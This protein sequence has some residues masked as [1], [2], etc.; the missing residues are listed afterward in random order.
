MS[1]KHLMT[2]EDLWRMPEIPGKNVEL[3]DGEVVAVSPAGMGHGL[4]TGNLYEAMK[5]HVRRNALGIVVG[6]NV[7]YVLRRD[8]DEVRAPDVSFIALER[9]PKTG[10]LETRFWEGPPTLAVEVVSPDD[11]MSDV[12]AK[13]QH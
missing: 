13:V 5:G 3:I 11:R 1:V 8:P 7:G 4:I 10:L 9:V 6:D 2:A 12:D